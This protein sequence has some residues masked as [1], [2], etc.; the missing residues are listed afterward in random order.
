MGFSLALG[1]FPKALLAGQLLTV[2][3]PLVQSCKDIK[4]CHPKFAEARRDAVCSIAKWV[5]L[6]TPTIPHVCLFV[7]LFVCRICVTVGILSSSRNS[8][9]S[10]PATDAARNGPTNAQPDIAQNGPPI[11]AEPGIQPVQDSADPEPPS[12]SVSPPAHDSTNTEPD[13]AASQPS[14]DLDEPDTASAQNSLDNFGI[15]RLEAE[16]VFESFLCSLGDYTTDSRGDI[17]AI[18]REAAMGGIRTLLKEVAGKNPE[19]I[20]PEMYV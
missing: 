9:G 15:S 13:T 11:N 5:C 3:E 1:G 2:L 14:Q 20:S 12:A 10:K 19:L 7:C 16:A 18:V 4:Q 6:A 8:A 17:G